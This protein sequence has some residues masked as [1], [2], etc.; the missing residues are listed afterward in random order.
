MCIKK[1]QKEIIID[2]KVE[3]KNLWYFTYNPMLVIVGIPHKLMYIF[4]VVMKKRKL[5][6]YAPWGPWCTEVRKIPV[7]NIAR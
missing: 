6:F 1:N 4:K 3:K 7:N 5:F 2:S